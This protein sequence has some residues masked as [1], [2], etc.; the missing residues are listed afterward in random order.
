M[1]PDH[2]QRY[3]AALEA[4]RFQRRGESTFTNRTSKYPP[5]PSNGD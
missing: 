4:Y 1:R 3:T 2:K 5:P